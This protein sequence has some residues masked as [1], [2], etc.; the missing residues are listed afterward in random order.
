MD[1]DDNFPVQCH[2]KIEL[3]KK[4]KPVSGDKPKN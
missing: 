3:K 1:N 4:K 2:P